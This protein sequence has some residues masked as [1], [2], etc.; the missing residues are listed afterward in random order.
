[1]RGEG[2]KRSLIQRLA[3]CTHGAPTDRKFQGSEQSGCNYE[4][5]LLRAPAAQSCLILPCLV[6]LLLHFF[7]RKCKFLSALLSPQTSV[8]QRWKVCPGGKRNKDRRQERISPSRTIRS[9]GPGGQDLGRGRG[10]QKMLSI[11]TCSQGHTRV[12]SLMGHLDELRDQEL[13]KADR[14]TKGALVKLA[15]LS[16]CSKSHC[17][18]VFLP[19]TP[20]SS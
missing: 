9:M 16:P 12:S 14:I 18:N 7:L 15:L 5:P 6:H 19:N 1:V 20:V 13:N 17:P 11:L 2:R 10:R 3:L 8:A 4:Q